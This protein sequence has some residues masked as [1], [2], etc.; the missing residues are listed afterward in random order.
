MSAESLGVA[1]ARPCAGNRG[2][3]CTCPP[4][5]CNMED[6]AHLPGCSASEMCTCREDD[7]WRMRPPNGNDEVIAYWRLKRGW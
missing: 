1:G 5:R 7:P 6:P 2:V 3:T 4:M